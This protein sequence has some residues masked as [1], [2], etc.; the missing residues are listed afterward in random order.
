MSSEISGRFQQSDCSA[1]LDKEDDQEINFKKTGK[2][3]IHF[4]DYSLCLPSPQFVS[5]S[6]NKSKYFTSSIS[7]FGNALLTRSDFIDYSQ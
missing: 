7:T 4:T 2:Y 1:G 5:F 3:T 6:L